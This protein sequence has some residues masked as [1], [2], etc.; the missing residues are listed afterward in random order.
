MGHEDAAPDPGPPGELRH[1]FTDV[2]A[3]P[4]PSDWVRVLDQVSG[5]PFY[6]GYKDLIR[7]LLGPAPGG[8][9]LDV[10]AGTGAD[11][12]RLAGDGG[13]TVVAVD[14]ASTMVA[15]AR[16]RGVAHAAAA[17][18]HRLPFR[19]GSFDGAWA[20]RVI[21]HLDDPGRAIDELIRV[22]VPGGRVVLA[23][24]DYDTQVVDVADQALARRLLRFRADRM[25]RN[26]TLAH[27]HA[28]LL[29]DRRMRQ[30]HVEARTL[31]VRDPRAVD[32]VLGLRSWA[33]TAHEQGVFTEAEARAWVGRFDE[34]VAGGRF[35]YAV[36]FFITAAVT[37]A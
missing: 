11:A 26:G 22:V 3:Q 28:G 1:G 37:P 16:E 36:T 33:E 14:R 21:Q 32:H 24:P 10:G 25:L 17:D 30:V 5:E 27:R 2:D 29:A 7:Q 18:A 4:E 31:V 12:V 20:D 15:A 23:D 6:A 19:D 34:A 13:V 9:Y 35:T 8:R